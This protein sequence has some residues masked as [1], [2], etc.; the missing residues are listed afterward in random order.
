MRPSAGRKSDMSKPRA[1][2]RPRGDSPK[3]DA[4]LDAATDLFLEVGYGA[5]SINMLVARMGGSK[6]T[7]YAYFD[8]KEKL[9]EAVVDGLL[10]ELPFAA[11]NAEASGLSL[12]AG[13]TL[14]GERLLGIVMSDRH[15]ALARVV[16]AEARRFPELGRIYF[17]HGPA[18]ARR[19]TVTFIAAHLH[20]GQKQAEEA[21]SWFFSRLLHRWFL[22]RLCLPEFNPPPAAV[23][24]EVAATVDGLLRLFPAKTGP[25]TKG[26]EP[27]A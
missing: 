24:Q 2:A 16:I 20:G 6:S 15:I 23:R 26:E 9:F 22:E 4:I 21:A 11:L 5:S 18:I 7:I 1:P 19:G 14:I 25:T 8:S 10:R 3:R 13:L 17:D 12:H 27:C